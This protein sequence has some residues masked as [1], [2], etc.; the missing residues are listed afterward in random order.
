MTQISTDRMRHVLLKIASDYNPDDDGGKVTWA[1]ADLMTV[2]VFLVQAVDVLQ[3]RVNNL[4]NDL[5]RAGIP[6]CEN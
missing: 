2:C 4:E 6:Q 5:D 3:E 1:D